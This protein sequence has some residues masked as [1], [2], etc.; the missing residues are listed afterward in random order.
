VA[1]AR[2]ASQPAILTVEEDGTNGDTMKKPIVSWPPSE[3]DSVMVKDA[4]L[5]GT[6]MKTKGFHEA[7][8]RVL[9]PPPTEASDPV[10]LKRERAAARLASRWYGL[11]ELEAPS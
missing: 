3:G 9:V 11:S 10:A 2:V 7:R 1:V 5:V 4:G 6:V 8:F